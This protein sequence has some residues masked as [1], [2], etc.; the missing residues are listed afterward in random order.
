MFGYFCIRFTDFMLNDKNVLD[1]TN[2][3][4]PNEYERSDQITLKYFQ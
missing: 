1:Y 2:L 4:P 3:F